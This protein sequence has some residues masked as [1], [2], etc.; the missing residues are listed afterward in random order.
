MVCNL[1]KEQIKI[2]KFLPVKYKQILLELASIDD[3]IDAGYTKAGAYKA[4]EKGV[5]S[6]RMCECLL[7]VLGDK[8]RPIL[9]QALQEFAL[10]LGC[11]VSC[12]EEE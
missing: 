3:L 9:L 6:D 5:I 7:Q 2:C 4:K 8:A 10:Q 12:P 11:Q 1:T